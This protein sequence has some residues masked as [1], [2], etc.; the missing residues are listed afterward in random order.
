MLLEEIKEYA[1][2]PII[3]EGIR[4]VGFVR[5]QFFILIEYTDLNERM[6][7]GIGEKNFTREEV[8]EMV[9]C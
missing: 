3:I 5:G 1:A 8:V 4:N 6:T 2:Y 7:E 9:C